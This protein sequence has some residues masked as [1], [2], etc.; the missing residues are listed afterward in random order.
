[1]LILSL[2]LCG[3]P[4]NSFLYISLRLRLFILHDNNRGR[5]GYEHV[6][7]EFARI[8]NITTLLLLPSCCLLIEYASIYKYTPLTIQN[9]YIYSI[10]TISYNYSSMSLLLHWKAYGCRNEAMLH[11]CVVFSVFWVQEVHVSCL[12][13]T[14]NVHWSCTETTDHQEGPHCNPLI[15]MH[16]ELTGKTDLSSSRGHNLWSTSACVFFICR[17]CFHIV[18]NNFTL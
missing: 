2:L 3:G 10:Y 11:V 1:M 8:S 14:V 17:L 6:F 9:V 15:L 5:Q 4:G 16:S 13:A 18:P 7:S 12:T